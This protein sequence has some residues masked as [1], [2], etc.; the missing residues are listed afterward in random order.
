MYDKLVYSAMTCSVV[1]GVRHRSSYAQVGV[2]SKH[3]DGSSWLLAQMFPSTIQHLKKIS[4]LQNG[5]IGYFCLTKCHHGP[6]I[7]ATTLWQRVVNLVQQRWTV[8][9]IPPMICCGESFLSPKCRYYVTLVTPT[10]GTVSHHKAIIS[11]GQPVD[12]I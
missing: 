10:Q 2:L 7:I 11:H 4:Y 6:S 5:G 1:I 9:P 3:L 12:K 8:A